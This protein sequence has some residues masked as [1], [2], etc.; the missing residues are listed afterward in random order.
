VGRGL[1]LK[2]FQEVAVEH[3]I[4]LEQL[5]NYFKNIS[6]LSILKY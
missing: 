5:N 4:F 2:D 1:E 6:G 3:K